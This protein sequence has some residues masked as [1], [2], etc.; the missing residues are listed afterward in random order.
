MDKLI[1]SDAAP[2][3]RATLSDQR[4]PGRREVS[5]PH[6]IPLLREPAV[7]VPEPEAEIIG[8]DVNQVE[9]GRRVTMSAARGI[10]LGV[11]LGTL[12]WTCVGIAV[13]LCFRG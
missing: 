3:A 5:N 10:F 8:A 12:T 11:A 7:A 9:P 4:R 2:G 6:L 1:D 13:W